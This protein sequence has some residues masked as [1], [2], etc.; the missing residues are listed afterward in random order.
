MVKKRKLRAFLTIYQFCGFTVFTSGTESF[1]FVLSFSVMVF[2]EEGWTTS[3]AVQPL[4]SAQRWPGTAGT[5]RDDK[6]EDCEG[7]EEQGYECEG[8]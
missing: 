4:R 3:L 7:C 1:T 8:W 5:G 2:L 6:Q